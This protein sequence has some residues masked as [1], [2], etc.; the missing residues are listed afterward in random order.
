MNKDKARLK[1]LV[2]S[3][4]VRTKPNED[5]GWGKLT[6]L[7]PLDRAE[8]LS[9]RADII[10]ESREWNR[11]I[12]AAYKEIAKLRIDIRR[13]EAWLKDHIQDAINEREEMS[14]QI[15]KDL[16]KKVTWIDYV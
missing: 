9:T 11:S 8:L 6:G 4:M 14:K 5:E 7:S 13:Q 16:S 10:S 15:I 3:D 1:Y 12:T 2:E